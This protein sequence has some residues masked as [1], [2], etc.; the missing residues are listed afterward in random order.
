MRA[1]R[2]GGPRPGQRAR[3][4]MA[5]LG[6]AVGLLL[7]S[8]LGIEPASLAPAVAEAAGAGGVGSQHPNTFDPSSRT[9]P[10]SRPQ[11]RTASRATTGAAS[12]QPFQR[13]LG[14]AFAPSTF[15]LDP[16]QG[17]QFVSG[18]GRLEVD[19]PA[20]AATA[21]DVAAAGGSMSL[22]V[23]PVLPASGGSAGGSGRYSFGTYAVQV[24]DAQGRL[25]RSLRHPMVLKLHYDRSAEALDLAHTQAVVG[26]PVPPWFDLDPA[27]IRGVAGAPSRPRVV[28]PPA[29]RRAAALDTTSATLSVTAPATDPTTIVSWDTD[30]A[31]ATFGKPDPSSMDLSGGSLNT[32]YQISTPA[33]PGGLTPPI[34]LSYSSAGVAEQHNVQAAAPWVGEGWSLALGSISWG[35]FNV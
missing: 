26:G 21:A 2:A 18:D 4:A 9:S 34:Q 31:V 24:L 30:A 27:A 14:A 28:P 32:S 25:G 11:P 35:Q 7:S 33:G 23:R 19:V 6:L 17:G 22:L 5:S 16:V 1:I 10:V 3:R 12:P 8:V 29:V 20:G 15:G 13:D